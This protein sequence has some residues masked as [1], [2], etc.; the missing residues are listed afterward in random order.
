MDKKN[1]ELV[2]LMK[3]VYYNEYEKKQENHDSKVYYKELESSNAVF[4]KD[5]VHNVVLW[6]LC[7]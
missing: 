7:Q 6:A 2:K 4:S 5:P 3:A 1:Q